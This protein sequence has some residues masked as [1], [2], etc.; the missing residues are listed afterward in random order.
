VARCL[1][2]FLFP[3]LLIHDPGASAAQAP[4]PGCPLQAGP[5]LSLNFNCHFS[6]LSDA[7]AAGNVMLGV[8][9]AGSGRV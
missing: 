2:I 5:P 7:Q 3:K 6:G 8:S 1:D 9:E 4:E